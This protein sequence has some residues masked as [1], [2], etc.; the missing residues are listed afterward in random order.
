MRETRKLKR[1]TP[2]TSTGQ[3]DKDIGV[4]EQTVRSVGE[5]AVRKKAREHSWEELLKDT[6][7]K[8]LKVAPVKKLYYQSE[9]WNSYY[10]DTRDLRKTREGI[11]RIPCK[12]PPEEK[13]TLHQPKMVIV[14]DLTDTDD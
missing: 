1:I 12:T 10:E 8:S 4:L 6:E 11:K 9:A 3:K 7:Y 13:S 2:P 14:P 5:F